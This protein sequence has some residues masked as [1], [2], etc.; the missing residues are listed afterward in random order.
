MELHP[1]GWLAGLCSVAMIVGLA[2]AGVAQQAGNGQAA[3]ASRPVASTPAQPAVGAAKSA[4]EE[5]EEAGAEKNKDGGGIKIHGHWIIDIR[6]PDGTLVKHLDFQNSL[7]TGGAAGTFFA[8]GD[9]LLAAL[10]SGTGVISDPG[11]MFVGF[12]PGAATFPAGSDAT[13]LCETV[14]SAAGPVATCQMFTTSQSIFLI[15][16]SGF[17]PI[18]PQ[19]GLSVTV[20]FSP[21]VN[22]VLSGNWTVPS[23]MTSLTAV[24][25]WLPLCVASQADVN[26]PVTA[27]GSFAFGGS[28]SDRTAS[29][30]TMNGCTASTVSAFV[31]GGGAA[32]FGPFTSTYVPGAPQT[33][34]PGQVITVKVIISFS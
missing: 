5:G 8:T 24:Q 4:G 25:T 27:N 10:L 17:F 29:A 22:W 30:L 1:R 12:N 13:G 33:I 28:L 26:S 23:N 3:A 7:V 31:A 2:P 14:G 6:N 19:T 15:N 16:G 11:I 18:T 20:N 34:T 21:N 32:A 9:Q